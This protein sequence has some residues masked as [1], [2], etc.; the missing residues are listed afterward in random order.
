MASCTGSR[1]RGEVVGE[2]GREPRYVGVIWDITDRMA[3]E[4]RLRLLNETLEQ[5]VADAL[6]E[7][8]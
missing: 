2:E 7:R 6:A 8:R 5:R 4:E 3:V 1:R